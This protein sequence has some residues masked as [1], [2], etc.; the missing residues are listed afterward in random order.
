MVNLFQWIMF[1]YLTFQAVLKYFKNFNGSI[2][3]V[4][5]WKSKGLLESMTSPATSGNS[6]TPKRTNIQ[7]PEIAVTFE[8][9]C[10]EQDE[11]YFNHG[12][13]ITFFTVY[14]LYLW[15][16]DL[17]T[18]ITLKDCLFWAVKL[19]NNAKSW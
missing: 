18:D 8:E 13:V 19:T 16:H 7:N 1:W 12:N 15:S 3:K 10:L 6:F 2:D 9:N 5:R 14:E 11:V 4:L 17:K